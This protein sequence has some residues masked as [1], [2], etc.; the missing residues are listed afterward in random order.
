LIAK[1]YKKDEFKYDFNFIN[2]LIEV[3]PKHLPASIG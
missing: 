1:D 3:L 2:M